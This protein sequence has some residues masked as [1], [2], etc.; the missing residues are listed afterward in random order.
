MHVND[1]F[2]LVVIVM[3]M[4]MTIV[5]KQWLQRNAAVW[6]W[7]INKMSNMLNCRNINYFPLNNNCYYA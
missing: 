3:M 2:A 5:T 1:K 6:K 7:T 4:V